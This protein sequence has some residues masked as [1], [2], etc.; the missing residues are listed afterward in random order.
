MKYLIFNHI[1]G[2]YLKS[3]SINMHFFTCHLIS[4][5]FVLLQEI[6]QLSILEHYIGHVWVEHDFL[7]GQGRLAVALSIMTR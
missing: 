3:K 7:L 1:S 2:M 6:E 4:L 5:P